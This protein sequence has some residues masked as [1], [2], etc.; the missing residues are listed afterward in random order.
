VG[1]VPER[2]VPAE[3][4]VV[5]AGVVI[6][7]DWLTSQEEF[8]VPR[9]PGEG[10]SASS[11]EVGAHWASAVDA[12]PGV[13]ERAGLGRADFREREFSGL[14]GFSPNALQRSLVEE[15]PGLVEGPGLLL[16]T[17]PPG[18][19][20]TEAA[21]WAAMLMARRSGAGGVGVAMPTMATVDA[22]HRRVAGYAEVS[23][24]DSAA[25]TRVHSMSWLSEE[26]ESDG[27][28][29]T[30]R[31]VAAT[32]AAEWL[33]TSRRGLLAPL[34][35]FTV[36]QALTGVLPVR[37][38]VLRLL[39]LSEKV[40]V[41]DEAH[42]YGPWMQSLLLMLLEWL[43]AMRAPVVLLSATLTGATARSLVEAYLRGSCPG[44]GRGGE[45]PAWEP[46]YP[47]WVWADAAG[48]GIAEPR[49][50]E[51]ER[52]RNLRLVREPVRRDVSPSVELHRLAVIRRHLRPV[53]ES[54]GCVL[55]CCTTVAEAQETWAAIRDWIAEERA[56]G[57]GMVP[58][59][60]LLHARFR[61]RDRSAATKACE[62]AFGKDGERPRSAV[63]VATQIVEQSLDLDFDL[64]VSDLAPMA[65]L[66]QRSGR[67]LRHRDAGGGR[68][69][70]ADRRPPWLGGDPALVVLDPVDARGEFRP[71]RAWKAVYDEA[72]LNATSRLLALR[73]DSTV[74]IPGDVQSL[75]DAVYDDTFSALALE[76]G[77]ERE[78]HE[79]LHA[80]RLAG[81]AAA[82]SLA[83]MTRIPGP[84]DVGSNLSR[85]SG[86][87][88]P[89]DPDL[90]TTRLGADS[91]RVV[92]VHDQG[93][94]RWTL[95]EAGRVPVSGWERQTR[96]TREEAR[97]LAQYLI[98]V[99]GGWTRDRPELHDRLP[100]SW[101]RNA[102]TR[103]WLP[104]VMRREAEEWAG[105]LTPG[106]VTYGA[107][108][109]TVCS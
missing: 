29:G 83:S 95:D 31:I 81:E 75:V 23:L 89:V 72:L 71:P 40:V 57:P 39:G 90:I 14:F 46:E 59:L 41:I 98:P 54:G 61:A 84:R 55:V 65:M 87:S 26:A 62:S 18:D 50:V 34:S 101:R 58:E 10:W 99:P 6:V 5:V 96:L 52:A 49:S 24:R 102:V 3:V 86:T 35:V 73:G 8:I 38:N 63:L 76:E 47:G 64:V 13:V 109:L 19:G 16:V 45:L 30:S 48:G 36:D 92:C 82:Q 43:G 56:A 100:E 79:A 9:L 37:Y 69:L 12:A 107:S 2:V 7:A 105:E 27:P 11:A 108:G 33:H 53:M 60:H 1:A 17:A 22:M 21:W 77:A 88:V 106:R 68:D 80:E 85:L 70:H 103:G 74:A 97:R 28:A 32:A 25:L 4:A 44:R 78:R 20:K 104:L 42:S 93:G 67:C 91:A 66:L 51:S 15:L 94:G